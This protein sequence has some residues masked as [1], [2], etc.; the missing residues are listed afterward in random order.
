MTGGETLLLVS[1]DGRSRDILSTQFARAGYQTQKAES[2]EEALEHADNG[3]PSLAVVD[4]KLDDM[5]GYSLC[6]ELRERFGQDLPIILL[7]ADRT[8]PDDRVAGLL[9]GADDYL[10][11][12][13]NPDELLARVRRLLRPSSVR[14][15]RPEASLTPREEEVLRLLAAGKGQTAI[16]AELFISPK[17]V[18]SHIQNILTKLGVH[19]RAEAVAFAYQAGLMEPSQKN[20]SG[21]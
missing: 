16:A 17:T 18:G 5:S 3:P 8:D 13:F 6:Y 2:G 4:L 20:D 12:P 14:R 9:I 10:S 19:T 21:H 15:A 11:R 7:S 1:S